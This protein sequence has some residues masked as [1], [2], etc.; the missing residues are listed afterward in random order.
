M[1]SSCHMKKIMLQTVQSH[2]GW[3]SARLCLS[4][5]LLQAADFQPEPRKSRI[6]LFCKIWRGLSSASELLSL[7]SQHCQPGPQACHLPAHLN[8]LPCGFLHLR[9]IRHFLN[10]NEASCVLSI[11]F[12]ALDAHP[13]SSSA[14][15]QRYAG[16]ARLLV[17]CLAA[18]SALPMGG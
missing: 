13:K 17:G 2:G 8:F 9:S 3:V 4:Q 12:T 16:G 18:M 10:T 14:R 6:M 5:L 11:A 15:V 1:M 7:L